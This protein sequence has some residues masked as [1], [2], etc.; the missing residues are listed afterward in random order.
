MLSSGFLQ[1]TH[2]FL[3]KETMHR[4]AQFILIIFFFF[5]VRRTLV[6]CV[7]MCVLC[8]HPDSRHIYVGQREV[9]LHQ[10]LTIF[11]FLWVHSF[12]VCYVDL[13]FLKRKKR[14]PPLS[15]SLSIFSPLDGRL[16]LQLACSDLLPASV[17]L[18]LFQLYSLAQHTFQ[19][20]FFFFFFFMNVFQA[21]R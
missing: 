5:C 18:T 13:L 20:F 12:I 1:K 16:A 10:Q 8:F 15:L 11:I 17:V 6:L 7:C 4:E 19:V 3:C 14:F 9:C 21:L 2:F